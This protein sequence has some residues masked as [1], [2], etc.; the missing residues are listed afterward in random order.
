ME[1]Q[2]LLFIQYN[3]DTHGDMTQYAV[4]MAPIDGLTLAASY[5]DF[6]EA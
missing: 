2:T 5:Y 6:G 3:G 4:T 1:V